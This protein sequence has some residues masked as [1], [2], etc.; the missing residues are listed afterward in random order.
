MERPPLAVDGLPVGMPDAYGI[1]TLGWGVLAWAEEFLAQPDGG[2][3]GD[4]WR[5]TA[6]QARI[7]AW[8][9]AVDAQGRWL[10]RRGQIVLPKGA[11]KSP[12]AA[13]LCCCE[14]AGEVLFDGFDASGEAVGRPHPSPHVQLA[15]V[16]QDQTD[17]TM[18]LV[19]A[20]LREGPAGQLID[21]LDLG[22]TRVR[23]RNG[24]LQPVTASANSR[25]GQRLT[26]A[27]IDE[28]H[29]WTFTNGGHRLAAT[30]RRNLGKMDGRS[31]EPLALDTPVPTPSGWTT[32]GELQP[33]DAVY[34]S[35]GRAVEVHF[36]TPVFEDRPCLRVAFDDGEEIVASDT[37]GWTVQR[38][39][40][41]RGGSEEVTLTTAEL[42]GQLGQWHL[43]M[44]LVAVEG[45]EQDLPVDPYY[46][47]LWL[48]DGF[49][50]DAA[51]CCGHAVADELSVLVKGT[52]DAHEELVVD[53]S[54][55]DSVRLRPRQRHRLC[56]WGHDWSNDEVANGTLR[57]G[58]KSVTCGA[59]ARREPRLEVRLL[60]M[61]EKLRSIGVLNDKHIPDVYLRGSREQRLALLQGLMDSDGT[62]GARG[63]A[64]FVNTNRRLA[65]QVAE[66]LVSLGHKVSVSQYDYP[67][68]GLPATHVSFV[69]TADEPVARLAGKVARHRAERGVWSSRRF[70]RSVESVP[71]VP[72]RCV[73]ID[74]ADHLFVVGRRNTLTHNTTNAWVPGEDSVA[75]LTSTY[76]D[77]VA[78][79]ASGGPRKVADEGV[80]RFHPR[81]HVSNLGDLDELRAGLE[82][83]YRDSPWI[84]IDRII[85]EVLDPATHP[86]DARRYYLNA[87]V[88]ADD[89]L[90]TAEEWAECELDDVLADGEEITL[91]FD[92]SKNDDSTVLVAMRV[93]DRFASVIGAMEKPDSAPKDWEVDRA[94]FDGLVT[95]MFAQYRVV[96]FYSDVAHFESYVDRWSAQYGSGLECSATN[97]SAVG[98]DMRGRLAQSTAAVERLVAGIQDK[99]VQHDGGGLLRRHVLN[100]RRRP[101][102]Y[103]VSFGKER[104]DSP[105][106]VDGFAALLLADMARADVIAARSKHRQRSGRV[107]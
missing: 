88:S 1:P 44:P 76:A 18:S 62:V 82:Q 77:K 3:A 70:V 87:V 104:R 26:A 60:T 4:P 12:L 68:R 21:G 2:S 96:G 50:G 54:Y 39:H 65:E 79:Q 92:G 30:L 105:R 73:G 43:A 25:E 66:L 19:L 72:T 64:T 49:T 34:G 27:V 40:R 107:W 38:S 42:A 78:E 45:A 67:E 103:G 95:T 11:G 102:S 57:S 58:R 47:G 17:N 83:L 15:A 33:G 14:L 36:A 53:R 85:A 75:E 28:P 99:S 7:V 20:M 16:S 56:R 51:I 41:S 94:F 71:S 29:L 91:G 106:K 90:V 24:L 5:W 8:W 9:Y 98:W 101:N 59:C 32:V 100:A 86:A 13:A 35:D 22:V 52:L 10:Y 48:G 69:P 97:K 81:A 6:T 46:L 55:S 74:T 31:I 89:A 63:R 84:N 80:L 23:T 93:R 37:H 61:R